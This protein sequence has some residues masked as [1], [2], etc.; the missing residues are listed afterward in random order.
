M[1]ERTV[2]DLSKY[3]FEEFVTFLFERDVQP[4]PIQ[5]DPEKWNPWHWHVEAIFDPTQICEYY[6]RLFRA[7]T[8]LL[9]Q[10]SRAQLEEGFWA[11]QA[12]SLE[13]SVYN[14]ISD[15]DLPFAVRNDCIT[16]MLDLFRN[17]FAKEP[18]ETAG[19]MWWDSLCYDWQCGN[20]KR[21]RGGEDLLLQDV[22]FRTLTNILELDSDFCHGAA[23]HGLGHL[24]HPET[25]ELVQRF[26]AGH[27]RLNE[28]QK[29][30]ALAAAKFKIL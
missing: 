2:V 24:H 19:N 1:V 23:L 17:F 13:C 4:R 30:Y 10:F 16:S 9:D 25:E 5:P 14:L 18:L 15:T 28:G 3:T 27:P 7:P 22:M 26:I 20:R 12:S 11:I 21:E 29:N 6:I 8:F